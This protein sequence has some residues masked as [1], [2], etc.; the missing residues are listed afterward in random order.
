M[1][2]IELKAHVKNRPA[3]KEK[4]ADFSSFCKKVTKKDTYYHLKKSNPNENEKNYI[5]LRIREEFEETEKGTKK[6]T[7]L[8]YKKKELQTNSDGLPVEVNDEKET[9]IDDVSCLEILIKDIGFEKALYKEK[10]VEDYECPTPFGKALLELCSVQGLGDFLEIEILSETT[11]DSEI[12]K[13]QEELKKL[14]K[15]SGIPESEIEKKYYSELLKEKG[16]A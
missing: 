3:L 15:K 5:S 13:I 8:T 14:L 9:V 2:E 6:T 1:K 7:Y 4:L 10:I 12:K 11:E 16:L